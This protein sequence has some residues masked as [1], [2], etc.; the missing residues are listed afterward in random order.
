VEGPTEAGVLRALLQQYFADRDFRMKVTSLNGNVKWDRI[1]RESVLLIKE[2]S[3]ET[4]NAIT[5]TFFD[6]YGR[7]A[8]NQWPDFG[9][10]AN[11]P[12][13]TLARGVETSLEEEV[14]KAFSQGGAQIRFIPHVQM[15][16]LE[17]LFFAQP[18]LLAEVF[19][20]PEK[21]DELE[22]SRAGGQGKL[23]CE[24]INDS[25][26]TAPSKRIEAI[27]SA[28]KK[29]SGQRSHA[30]RF[31]QRASLEVIRKECPLFSAW[32]EKIEA[33]GKAIPQ[34]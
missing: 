20:Q 33:M 27:F 30:S 2:N 32:L 3:R 16:E 13:A 4:P 19:E 31:A 24:E 17:A 22:A 26:R 12:V 25:P 15:H 18:E 14:N 28:Y 8:K 6:Y 5:A 29:G 11:Q 7:S 9:A 1:V 21:K 34:P 23:A 10:P